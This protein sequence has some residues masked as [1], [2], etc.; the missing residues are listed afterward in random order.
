M[1]SLFALA[2]CAVALA[3]CSSNSSQEAEPEEFAQVRT[4]VDLDRFAGKDVAVE[5]KF[6]HID[7][8]HGTVTLESGLVIYVPHFDM[9]KRGDDWLKYVGHS[10]RVEGTLH[11]EGAHVPGINGPLIDV[12][13]FEA[14]DL[15]E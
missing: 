11:T 9:F 10:V 1:K 5:G 8:R 13:H 2:A 6:G 15:T 4:R 3:S 7:A 12:R 14:L